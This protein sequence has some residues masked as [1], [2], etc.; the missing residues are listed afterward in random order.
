MRYVDVILPLPLDGTFT[1]SVPE[2]MEEKVVAGMRVLV[3]LGKSKKYIAMVADVHSEKPDFNCKPIEAVLDSYPSLL[4][5]QYRLWQWISDYYMSPLGDVYNAAMPAGMKSTEKFKP[6]MELYVELASSYRN[7]QALHVALNMVQ[8]ALKQSKTLTTFLALSH[9][10]SLEGDTPREGIKKVTKEE[11]MNEARCTA[12]VVKALIDRGILFTYELE[13]GRLNT[14]GESHLDQIK[15]LSMPQQDAYNQILMQMLKKN[16]VLL[17][18]VTSSGKTEIYIHLIRKAIEEHRQVL[19]LLPEIALTVQIMERLHKVFGD[20]LGIYHSKY[21]DAERVEIWQKQLSGHP[22]DVILGARSAVFLPFQKL[23]L[24]IID[25]EHET[26]FKQQ[27][28]APRYHARS[29]AIVLANMYPEAKVLLGTATPSMESYY[30]AQQ[31]KYGLVE[32]KTRYKDIQLPE[33]QVVDVKDL[34]HRKMM[35]GVY[36]PVLLAAVKE[37]LKNGEQAILFQNRRGF[38]P[39]IECKVCGWVPKCKNCDVSLTLHKS[40]NL[41][42][43]HYCGYTY[44]VPTECPNCGSAELMGRGIGTERIEDQIS[45]IFPEARIARMDLDT[46]RTRNAYERLISDFSS[47]K[48]NLLIGTQMISK[49]LDFDKVSVVGILNADSMLNYPDFRAYEHAFMMMAQ[50]SGRAGR[51]GKR[52]LVILQTKNPT[53]PIISQV[54]HNDYDSLF[55]GILEERRMFHYPP[56]FHLINVFLKH[57][58]EKICQQASLELGKTLRGWFGERV[59]GPDKPAVARVKTM[60]IRKIVIKLENGIDQKKVR[61]YLKYAQQMMAKDPRYGALQIYYDVDPM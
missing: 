61:E 36:S 52:G 2:G 16:V 32:L 43:C 60:N 38:A 50:V 17:H 8:R 21:S 7:E 6:K 56:F 1:Y 28:P 4:P 35:T 18:G 47:G 22:Y 15:P 12:A 20:R 51:K 3:P 53:L 24:V 30:N 26:S 37:A 27:D 41:L 42:T 19:Y 29:A 59:L 54:V 25:E 46:T 45:E 57:K 10:D 58:H 40:I 9:W 5:Q 55:K 39:M 44:P 11:L 33:I 23:G 14:A 49:G 34:R 13:V 31:G 48:T